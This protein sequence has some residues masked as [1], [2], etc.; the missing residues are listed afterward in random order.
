M[1][2]PDGAE[3][4]QRVN[5]VAE[6]SVV[7]LCLEQGFAL[8]GVCDATPTERADEL[9]RW[10]AEGKHGEMSYLADHLDA[11]LDT[12]LVLEGATSAI[13]VADAY[14]NRNQPNDDPG[15]ARGMIARYARGTDYHTVLKDRLHTICDEL[16]AR[17]PEHSFRAFTDTAPVSER[18]FA[19]R[20]GIGWIGKNTLVINPRIGSWFCL[21]GILTTLAIERP[22]DQQPIRDHC[23][24]C[25]RC[26]D[27]CPTDA[28]TPYSVDASRCIS[29]LTIEHR[30]PIEP[31]FFEP[32]GNRIAGCDICQD[33]CPHNR[34]RLGT[35]QPTPRPEYEPSHNSFDL[36]EVV[37]WSAEARSEALRGS[38]LKRIKLDMFRR[39]ALIAI[40]NLYREE[41]DA[42]YLDAL[43]S[44]VDDPSDLVSRTARDVLRDLGPP[45]A[46]PG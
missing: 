12:D 31:V 29:Y 34:P 36:F 3:P 40:G 2:R 45:T 25:T 42:R 17:Y 44:A 21:G 10:L 6:M 30:S 32:I 9:R 13:L 33:V 8:A 15:P 26:I 28:I 35:R 16:R 19:A 23:G 41:G 7:D 46:S 1:V 14:S 4:A 18:E 43:R 11:Y 24:T 38:A 22:D 20:A 5:A 27:A 37:G 39:N